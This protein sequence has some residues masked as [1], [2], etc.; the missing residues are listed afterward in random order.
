MSWIYI[1]TFPNGKQY[2]GQTSSLNIENRYLSHKNDKRQIVDKAIRKYGWESILKDEIE[3][4]EEFLD[5]VET[6]WIKNFNTLKPNG[7]NLETGGHKNKHLSEETKRKISKSSKG[8]HPSKESLKK[9]SEAQ[10]GRHHSKETKIKMSKFSKGRKHTEETKKKLSILKT[11]KSNPFNHNGKWL[12]S[13]KGNKFNL[14]N[15]NRAIPVL[16]YSLDG[17]LIKEWESSVEASRKL[18]ID[19]SD[20]RKSCKGKIKSAGKFKWLNK[21]Q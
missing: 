5:E 21:C 15:K 18:N 14:G 8:R 2:V 7:Y 9:M 10:K 6:L 4:P 19:F 1:F 17:E 11:G 20:I 16:Q 13:I 12:E 3:C